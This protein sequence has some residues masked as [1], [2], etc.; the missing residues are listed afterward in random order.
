MDGHNS[1]YTL[2]F[3][4]FARLNMII[5]LCYPA[6]TTHVYQGLDVVIFSVLKRYW[7]EERD[8]WER[9]KGERVS[10]Q[11]FLA[12]YGR[13]HIR[14]LTADTIRAAFRATGVWPF[15]PEVISAELM[16]PSKETSCEAHLPVIPPTPVRT[17]SKLL[18]AVISSRTETNVG[19]AVD[20]RSVDID[21]TITHLAETQLSFLVL[22]D[23]PLPPSSCIQQA[24]FPPEQQP[25][26]SASPSELL[27]LI[28]STGLEER[29]QKVLRESLQREAILRERTLDLQARGVLNSLYCET[30]RGQLAWHEL[31]KNQTNAVGKLVGDGLPR[32]LSGDEFYE[33]VVEHTAWQKREAQE[34]AT[35]K[36]EREKRAEAMA[37][38]RTRDAERI[39]E[40]NAIRAKFKADVE[41]WNH[42]KA[43]AKAERRKF[44]VLKPRQPPIK[45]AL[46]KP[47]AGRNE[48]SS[49]GS[50]TSDSDAGSDDE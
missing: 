49:E 41:E 45:R 34:K 5:I 4:L 18:R 47:S 39:K 6:H 7:S 25:N 15:N 2:E 24:T 20:T 37:A 48:E 28:P 38:W 29:L 33:K 27:Q 26:P 30:L 23:V 36:S 1:H 14:A 11:N 9:E 16:A 42:E 13:A 10:K 46:P 17:V 44:T 32:L 3:L 50:D 35:R 21:S 40:N 43:K 22:D 12:I 31:K 19:S 8:R